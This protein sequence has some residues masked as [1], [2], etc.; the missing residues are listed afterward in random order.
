MLLKNLTTGET[1]AERVSAARSPWRRLVGWL[2]RS[3]I[4]A[5]EG[6]LFGRCGAIHTLGMR[7]AIDIVFLDEHD[8]VEDVESNVEPGR[9]RVARPGAHSIL[10]MGPGFIE[11]HNVR[12]GHLLAL[13]KNEPYGDVIIRE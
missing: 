5:D 11:K 4:A 2:Y 12:V 3:S 6:L 13:A 10:E 1:L 8:R 9:A 7:T